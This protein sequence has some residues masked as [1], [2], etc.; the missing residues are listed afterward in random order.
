MRMTIWTLAAA[1]IGGV[2]L[3]QDKFGG[4]EPGDHLSPLTLKKVDSD[5]EVDFGEFRKKKD[6][7]ESEGKIVVVT[8]WSYKCPTGRRSMAEFK[9]LAE[10]CGEKEVEFVGICS[11]GESRDDLKK[12]MKKNELD[13]TLV[14]DGDG[15]AT[16]AFDAKV[17]TES[18]IIDTEGKCVYRG[19]LTPRR[20]VKYTVFDALEDFL[21]GK[22]L[23]KQRTR[24]RG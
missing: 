17:V 7:E 16:K 19:A 1:L 11:Y 23:K 24:A 14:F 8:F 9:K 12:Y 18:Y 15:K 20:R 3:P 6:D 10:T 21:E 22:E 2:A 13:Y 4:F 5:E